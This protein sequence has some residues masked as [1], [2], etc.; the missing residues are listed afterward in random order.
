MLVLKTLVLLLFTWTV[1]VKYFEDSKKFFKSGLFYI[2]TS[3]GVYVGI[4]VLVLGV[5]L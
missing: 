5:M 2:Y 1:L 3:L 4:K